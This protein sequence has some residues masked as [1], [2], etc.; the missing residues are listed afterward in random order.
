MAVL[1]SS[2]LIRAWFA[3]A[4]FL[5]PV[6]LVEQTLEFLSELVPQHF[7]TAPRELEHSRLNPLPSK[8]L[9]RLPLAPAEFT[10]LVKSQTPPNLETPGP[11]WGRRKDPWW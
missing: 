4:H 7:A 6:V 5:L 10:L 11:V 1:M 2:L 9:W 8:T 3:Q